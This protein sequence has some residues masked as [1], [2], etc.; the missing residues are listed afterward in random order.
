MSPIQIIAKQFALHN[1]LFNNVLEGIGDV[2]GNERV[3]GEVNHLQW[4]GGHLVNVRYR[5]LPMFGKPV[6]FPHAEKYTDASLP[7]PQ[8]RAI[9]ASIEYPSLSEISGYW[10]AIVPDFAESVS[11][12]GNDQLATEM[13]F[14]VPIGGKTLLDVLAFLASHEAYHIGQMSIIRKYLGLEAMSYK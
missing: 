7:P 1:R 11:V 10:N 5:F 3:S 6:S 2:K 4:I 9:S 12:L 14:S 8:T 13:P